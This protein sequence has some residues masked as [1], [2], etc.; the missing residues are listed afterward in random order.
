MAAKAKTLTQAPATRNADIVY[1][2]YMFKKGAVVEVR[3]GGG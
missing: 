2:G 1:A 3:F